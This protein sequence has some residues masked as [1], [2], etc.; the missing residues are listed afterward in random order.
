MTPKAGG[1]HS[2]KIELKCCFAIQIGSQRP[3]GRPMTRAS[4]RFI[5][6]LSTTIFLSLNTVT[7][8]SKS[9]V[10][11]N[12][13]SPTPSICEAP[14]Q[15]SIKTP[16]TN[17]ALATH[18]PNTISDP[19]S[20]Q[21]N[22]LNWNIQKA[23]NEGWQ[24]ALEL[25]SKEAQL[26]L[27]QEATNAEALTQMLNDDGF[28]SLAPGYHTGKV[29]TGVLT[30]SNNKALKHC[31]L[32][33]EEPWL[34]TPKALQ[35]SWY[36]VEESPELL[37]VINIHSINFT[38]GTKD[39]REQIEAFRNIAE[40][41]QG[42]MIVAGDFNTWSKKRTKQLNLAAQNLDLISV[43][44]DQDERKRF[45][46]KP[47]DYIFVRGFEIIDATTAETDSS[48]HNPLFTTLMLS[49]NYK[50]ASGEDY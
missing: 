12:S 33:H 32:Q 19:I 42:P 17:T 4:I 50:A 14:S 31:Y 10:E 40:E 38:L 6:V 3:N 7:A 13:S 26:I 24:D 1:N 41:H 2:G 39:Y 8:L 28:S 35:L 22:L 46:G 49:P 45:F 21:I 11:S 37:L 48:D 15:T 23:L 44:F 47:L 34:N 9:Q 25:Y 18:D 5:T 30:Y 27:L 20:G 29:Q 16:S 36:A 43:E